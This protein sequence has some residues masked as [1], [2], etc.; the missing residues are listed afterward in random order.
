MAARKL[1][2]AQFPIDAGSRLQ[3]GKAVVTGENGTAVEL[4]WL[5]APFKRYTIERGPSAS[6]PWTVIASNVAGDGYTKQVTDGAPS[7]NA[8][9][10]RINVQ[11]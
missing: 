1:A 8:P 6:G 4:T 5:S 3:L 2:T 11:P 7:E 10:Y 9:F